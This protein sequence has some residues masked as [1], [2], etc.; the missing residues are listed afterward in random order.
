[1]RHSIAIIL[2][3]TATSALGSYW[4]PTAGTPWQIV[5]SGTL[6]PPYPPNIQAIDG[7]L[8]ANPDSTWAD[9]R[10]RGY[11][12][13]CY[14]SAGSYEDWRPDISEFNNETDI[15]APLQ[16]WEGEWWLNTKSSNVR[17]IMMERLDLASQKGCDAVDP[18]NID[19]YDNDGGGLDLTEDDAVDYVA[20]LAKEAHSRNMA[21]GLKNGG[22]IVERLL[23][24]VDFQVNEQCE[25]YSECDMFRPFIAASK[26]VFAIEYTADD[27]TIPN[28][29]NVNSVCTNT[30]SRSFSTLIKH[31]NLNDWL[32]ACPIAA[33][34]TNDSTSPPLSTPSPDT[35]SGNPL[36]TRDGAVCLGLL[37]AAIFV[38]RI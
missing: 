26:P 36:S 35:N 32:I 28:T 23:S 20:F 14:F 10:S 4:Q 31:M 2:A 11:K 21:V 25:E 13:I 24:V 7:D 27:D 29:A 33:T 38:L 17:R 15:G 30:E 6:Q 1:M 19:A 22:A 18:D 12:T 3:G 37:A 16:G 8:Y 9:L 34:S 5:L